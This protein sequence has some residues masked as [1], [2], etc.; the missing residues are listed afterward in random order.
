MG[1]EEVLERTNPLTYFTLFN[2]AVIILK[3][4]CSKVI[5]GGGKHTDRKL[6][7]LLMHNIAQN[8]RILNKVVQLLSQ[9]NLKYRHI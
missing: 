1:E 8:Y 6:N 7:N 2:I 4:V 5:T 9:H 3:S